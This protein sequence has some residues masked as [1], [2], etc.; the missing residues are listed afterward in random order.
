[1]Q[2]A[3]RA[4]GALMVV[5]VTAAIAVAADTGRAQEQVSGSEVAEALAGVE[6]SMT[7]QLRVTP[8]VVAHVARYTATPKGRQ[9]VDAALGR[10]ADHADAIAQAARRHGVPQELAAVA[11]VESGFVNDTRFAYPDAEDEQGGWW[12]G[13]GM[14][15]FIPETARIHGMRVGPLV[16]ERLDV[17]QETD[18]AMRLL[19]KEYAYFGDWLLAAAAYNQGR[20]HVRDAVAEDGTNDVWAL[21]ESGGL[22]D[23]VP[24]LAAGILVLYG[25]I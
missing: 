3:L 20:T 4:C 10:Y 1:M 7:V 18:A 23:Y 16:D 19:A 5:A 17:D 13:A 9:Q 8:D 25:A 21:V 22:N 24:H 12:R 14:W 2:V 11:F 6:D 15:M